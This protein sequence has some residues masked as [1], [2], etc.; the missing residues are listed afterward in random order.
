MLALNLLASILY[1]TRK[2]W[3]YLL[4]DRIN[5]NTASGLKFY[6][7]IIYEEINHLNIYPGKRLINRK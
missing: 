6:I 3:G 2:L 5:F 7:I 4:L 1:G